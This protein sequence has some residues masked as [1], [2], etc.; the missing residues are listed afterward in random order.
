GDTDLSD[1]VQQSEERGD[2]E[3]E[4]EAEE[5]SEAAEM[6][7]RSFEA[8]GKVTSHLIS[9]QMESTEMEQWEEYE[10]TRLSA[11]ESQLDEPYTRHMG[12]SME[13]IVGDSVLEMEGYE[14]EDK[15]Y[16]SSQDEIGEWTVEDLPGG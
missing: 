3:E 1:E 4:T 15:F 7:K 12:A 16:S 5:N 11:V 9:T 13:G 6:L 2:T 8:M 14:F 10:E